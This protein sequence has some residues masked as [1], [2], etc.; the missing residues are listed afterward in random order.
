MM[1]LSTL[2]ELLILAAAIVYNSVFLDFFECRYKAVISNSK[3]GLFLIVVSILPLWLHIE[4]P[5]NF[6]LCWCFMYLYLFLTFR[7]YVQKDIFINL[8]LL[9]QAIA[10]LFTVF[11][12]VQFLTPTMMEKT[13]VSISITMV[14]SSVLFLLSYRVLIKPINFTI[15]HRLS[16]GDIIFSLVFF[17]FSLVL[18]A[19]LSY[20]SQWYDVTIIEFTIFLLAA[21]LLMFLL[22]FIRLFYKLCSSYE[23]E[24]ELYKLQKKEELTFAYY[25]KN[26]KA[27]TEMAYLLH[28]IKN[29]LL[30][31]ATGNKEMIN[32]YVSDLQ[33]Q[34]EDMEPNFYSSIPLLQM[35]FTDKIEEA[36]NLNIQ[37]DI[38]NEDKDMIMFQEYDLVTMFSFLVEYAF[39]EIGLMTGERSVKLAIRE[40][41]SML[42]IKET[43]T[44]IGSEKGNETRTVP[45]RRIQKIVDKYGGTIKIETK[46]NQCLILLVFPLSPS[47]SSF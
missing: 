29:H 30:L 14:I 16:F 44:V 1:N 5:W 41:Q 36:K 2:F 21:F 18:L 28:D 32:T 42:V 10:M 17:T 19:G 8:M 37:L 33:V 9:L 24:T 43:F 23:T 13:S 40:I 47:K 6:V 35:L 38:H 25:K 39:N 11:F 15:F 22:F 3:N 4:Y 31:Q 12:L 45:Y 26:E 34:I 46:K 20:L 27:Q 7:V